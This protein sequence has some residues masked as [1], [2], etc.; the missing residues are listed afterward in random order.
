MIKNVV[1]EFENLAKDKKRAKYAVKMP[2]EGL[3]TLG[4][5]GHTA[6][7]LAMAGTRFNVTASTVQLFETDTGNDPLMFASILGRPETSSLAR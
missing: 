7:H 6:L 5:Q 3:P 4:L 2:E 1:R